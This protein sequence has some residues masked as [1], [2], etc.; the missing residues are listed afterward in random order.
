MWYKRKGKKTGWQVSLQHDNCLVIGCWRTSQHIRNLFEGSTCVNCTAAAA[1]TLPPSLA[2]PKCPTAAAAAVEFITQKVKWS[3]SLSRDS[4]SVGRSDDGARC[5]CVFYL[6]RER[7]R[8][9]ERQCQTRGMVINRRVGVKET[10]KR[11]E[12]REQKG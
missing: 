1:A 11:Q 12:N 5:V 10:W 9:R 6:L 3:A 8:E 4:Q 2:P 7:E